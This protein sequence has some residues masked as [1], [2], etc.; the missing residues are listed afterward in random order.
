MGS[1]VKV[2]TVGGKHVV[3]RIPPGTQTGTRFRIPGQGVARGNRVGDQ[4]VEVRVELP[5]TLGPEGEEAMKRL[6]EVLGLRY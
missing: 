1:K 2:R 5:E 4:I 6:A 3:L